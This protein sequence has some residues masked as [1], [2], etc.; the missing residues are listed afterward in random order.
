MFKKLAG[1]LLRNRSTSQT[2]VKN[3]VWLMVG[4]AAHSL[5][6]IVAIVAARLLGA[7]SWGVFAYAVTM[8][9]MFTI[10][11][12]VGIG[13]VLNRE[14]SRN[15][16]GYA[17]HLSTSFF[18]KILLIF[19]SIS[20]IWITAPFLL[21]VDGVR[22]FLLVICILLIFD[23]LRDFSFA[24]IRAKE[25]MEQEAVIKTVTNVGILLLGIGLLIVFRTPMALAWAYAIGSGMGLLAAIWFLRGYIKTMLVN[26]SRRLV[27]PI[28]AAAWPLAMVA[29]LSTIMINMDTI[30]IGHYRSAAEI[31]FYS[32]AQRPI[33]LFYTVSSLIASAVFP[34]LAKTA[35]RDDKKFRTLFEKISSAAF[36]VSLPLTIVGVVLGKSIIQALFGNQYLPAVLTFQLLILTLVIT[37]LSNIITN[38]VFAYDKQKLFIWTI[39]G[40]VLTNLVL[41]LLFIPRW[42]IAGS[43]VATIIAQLVVFIPLYASMKKINFF[44]I[45]R[46]IKKIVLASFAAGAVAAILSALSVSFYLNLPIDMAVYLVL[47]FA[48]KEPLAEDIASV[49]GVTAGRTESL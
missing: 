21:N 16:D 11:S 7:A 12:D 47:L 27:W 32:A 18:L 14:V 33:Q 35:K 17:E 13:G 26:F 49:F 43:A 34:V 39:A 4:E 6:F 28:F 23:S 9:S 48:T 19:L 5:R 40:G 29:L 10:V 41:D 1:L 8:A 36:L 46:N 42:G 30:I 38:G 37:F 44:L 15:P 20:L 25:K 31:G 45:F 22:S 24:I 2:V 3:T